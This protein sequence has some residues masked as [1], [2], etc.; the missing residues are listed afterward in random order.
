MNFNQI[1]AQRHHLVKGIQV[2]S[3]ERLNPTPKEEIRI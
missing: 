3:I 2:S 1:L